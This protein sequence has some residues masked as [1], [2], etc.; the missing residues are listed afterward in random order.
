MESAS[1]V[2][3]AAALGITVGW[4]PLDGDDARYEVIIAIPPAAVE[5]LADVDLHPLAAQIPAD[6]EPIG[7]IRVEVSAAAP[8]RQ[9]RVT[10]LKPM[11]DG[12][13]PGEQI[14]PTQYGA[15]GPSASWQ[16]APPPAASGSAQGAP[17]GNR[18]PSSV[19]P[20]GTASASGMPPAA[21]YPQGYVYPPPAAPAAGGPPMPS[22]PMP[23]YPAA[24]GPTPGAAPPTAYVG[25]YPNAY[26][27]APAPA[28]APVATAP[29]YGGPAA[30]AAGPVASA[31]PAPPLLPQTAPSSPPPTSA[32]P[33]V[34]GA[35]TTPY[36]AGATTETTPYG[37]VPPVSPAPGAAASQG[38]PSVSSVLGSLSAAFNGSSGGNG[39]SAGNGAP[40]VNGAPAGTPWWSGPGP[41]GG[42]PATAQLA[43]T[44]D[45]F[46]RRTQDYLNSVGKELG[47]GTN[48]LNGAAPSWPAAG[49]PA[50]GTGSSVLAPPRGERLDQPIAPQQVGQWN[51][52]GGVQGSAPGL[53]SSSVLPSLRGPSSVLAPPSTAPPN[54]EGGSVFSSGPQ[55]PA[56]F[57]SPTR[58][59]WIAGEGQAGAAAHA[60]R[61]SL[62]EPHLAPSAGR[63]AP[64]INHGMLQRPAG[65][66]LEADA[67]AGR[68]GA[69]PGDRLVLPQP[70]V[71][72]PAA[73]S[74]S[75]AMYPPTM[76]PSPGAAPVAPGVL[77][78]ASSPDRPSNLF[79]VLLAWVLLCGSAAGNLYLFWSYLD[80]RT[81]YRAL[82]RDSSRAIA[83][84]FSAA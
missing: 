5:R 57:P 83:R 27:V 45:E 15:P 36:A 44:V 47:M 24:A 17:Y 35:T 76:L 65:V 46:G 38:P 12:E 79:A 21:G 30:A 80:V 53:G 72:A 64:E 18:V 82:V 51:T 13:T 37:A 8:P 75:Q 48:P 67:M 73:G 20:P 68:P 55:F 4:R 66:P 43:Q 77:P 59:S 62:F 32:T 7:R 34:A 54:R 40:A 2:A 33:Y 63:P 26:G 25:P 49:G 71:M 3:M 70:P 81:K 29:I 50:A 9:Q 74:A 60:D 42:N 19:P 10:L 41:A 16:K 56:P 22:Y 31:P 23:A 28:A 69:N 11:V 39:S 84:R 78:A 61:P 52:A 14:R 58:P 1:L 6:I